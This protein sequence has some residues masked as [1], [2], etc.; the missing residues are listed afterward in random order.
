MQAS[1]N[2]FVDIYEGPHLGWEGRNTRVDYRYPELGYKGMTEQEALAEV[3]S[4]R[5][6]WRVY[7]IVNGEHVNRWEGG[8]SESSADHGAWIASVPR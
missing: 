7:Q 4:E 8:E 2:F 1:A 5:R 6:P 3:K